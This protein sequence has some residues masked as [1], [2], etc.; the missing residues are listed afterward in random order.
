[1][2]GRSRFL[3]VG[4]VAVELG[5]SRC[6][7]YGMVREGRIPH[8]RQGRAIRIPAEAFE[9]WMREQNERALRTVAGAETG[10]G[11]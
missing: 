9:H 4:D 5:V 11:R 10:D 1:M 8:V 3:R 2:E 7:A 6:R